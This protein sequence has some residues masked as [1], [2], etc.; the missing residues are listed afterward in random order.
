MV[1]FY[2]KKLS[3][4][5]T[6]IKKLPTWEIYILPKIH[7]RLS[8]VPGR[9]VISNAVHLRRNFQSP[10]IPLCKRVGLTARH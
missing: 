2:R 9:T 8:N 10:L 1:V 4:F 7:K 3:I 5:C 6:N